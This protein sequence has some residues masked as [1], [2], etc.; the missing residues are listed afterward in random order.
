MRCI[1]CVALITIS[2]CTRAA[3]VPL[4]DFARHSQYD[5]VQISPE[6]DYLAAT[7]IVKGKRVLSLI[8]MADMKG[9][10]L[11]PHDSDAVS[12]FWWIESHRIVYSVEEKFTDLDAPLLTG[13]LYAVNADGS[14]KTIIAG[15]RDFGGF[16]GI[17]QVIGPV[18][19]DT[20]HLL[21][22]T[23]KWGR[24][25]E[26]LYPSAQLVDG[27]GSMQLLA[28]APLFRASFVAD[29]A[30]QVRFAFAPGNDQALKVYYREKDASDWSLLFDSGKDKGVGVPLRFSRDDKGVYFSCPGDDA[31][32]GICRWDVATRQMRTLWS[33]VDSEATELLNT[34]DG[35]DAFAIR[36]LPSRPAL[37]L[38]D[39][40]A[41]EAELLRTL[42][43]QFPGQSVRL[44]SHTR[45]GEKVVVVVES[46][47][48]PG[49]FYLY[50]AKDK[51]LSF[52]LARQPWVKPERMAQMEP[53]KFAA[54]DGLTLHGYMTRPPGRE[55]E[56]KLPLV[57][58]VH[59]GPYGVQDT[60]T[61]QPDVQLLASHGYAVL[62]VNFRGSGGYGDKF[63]D[64]GLREWG[65]KMQDDVNDA[66]RWAI[67]QVHVDSARICIFGASYGGYAALEGA[68]KEPDLYRCA[69]GYVGIYDLRMMYKRGD[70]P[71]S[72]FGKNYLK[73]AIGEDDDQLFDR[74][75]IA[76]LDRLKARIM[77]VVGGSDS[78]VPEEQGKQLH[79]A[80][81]DH[82][83]EHDWIY[84]RNEAHGFYNEA[85]TVELYEKLLAFLDRQIGPQKAGNAGSQ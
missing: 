5:D 79:A 78:R 34:F 20:R 72:T 23:S 14:G 53:I 70:I 25:S 68:V 15:V 46:D 45:D 43:Q 71:Q 44:G 40:A 31:V 22:E 21:V 36:S 73:R 60:W 50:S 18:P 8:R 19:G 41:P 76:H 49:E 56:K 52:L 4:L 38:L 27:S 62:Q 77:L 10:N 63:R 42:T 30:G 7:G 9:V 81:R 75:P 84:Q 29:N 61:Y 51:K 67:A 74:S 26:N 58:F 66:T 69:I 85:H 59:G 12:A 11:N 35:R 55:T 13:E 3:E 17:A 16:Q 33:S 2:L 24:E 37:T 28:T 82:D 64:A 47:R 6:G 65:A 48:N 32:G 1:V 54:R 39:K 83:I 57:V 80:L